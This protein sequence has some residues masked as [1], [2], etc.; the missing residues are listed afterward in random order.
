MSIPSQKKKNAWDDEVLS[1]QGDATRRHSYDVNMSWNTMPE[2]FLDRPDLINK[3]YIKTKPP[4]PPSVKQDN[5]YYT[6]HVPTRVTWSHDSN[7][8]NVQ[9]SIKYPIQ[10]YHAE[11]QPR[12]YHPTMGTSSPLVPF[13]QQQQQQQRFHPLS[14]VHENQ[15]TNAPMLHP[16]ARAPEVGQKRE[17]QEQQQQQQ[18]YAQQQR[19]YPY[20]YPPQ[21][22][23]APPPPPPQGNPIQFYYPSGKLPLPASNV[24]YDPNTPIMGKP[25]RKK[26]KSNN[27]DDSLE[28]EMVESNEANYPDMAT[29]D[30]EAARTD[31]EAR[32]RKQKLR[33]IGDEYTPQWV[34]YNGQSKEGLCDTC[35]PGKWLQLKNSAYW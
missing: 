25:K 2:S 23:N 21:E 8:T 5:I 14:T 4:P 18:I 35:K 19:Y 15:P 30:V 28:E 7:D 33:F 6:H 34:R 11:Y 29:R 17:H 31:P 22:P 32:P 9:Q 26:Q 1:N 3:S 24:V 12:M 27:N 20:G 16:L 10:H 13:Q